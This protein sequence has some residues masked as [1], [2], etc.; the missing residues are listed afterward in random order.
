MRAALERARVLSELERHDEVLSLLGPVAPGHPDD[1]DLL[2]ELARAHLHLG[3]RRHHRTGLDL[4]RRALALDPDDPYLLA[5]LGQALTVS[6]TR[7]EEARSLL[8]AAVERA[9]QDPHLHLARAQAL[10]QMSLVRYDE[11]LAAADRAV[12]LAPRDVDALLLRATVL[13]QKYN[14]F[15]EAEKAE[16]LAA[17]RAVLAEDPANA[18]AAFLL[19]KIDTPLTGA[20]AAASYHE[21]VRRDPRHR[22]AIAKVDSVLVAPLRTGYWTLWLLTGIQAVLLARGVD[23]STWL[24]IAVFGLVVAVP[25]WRFRATRRKAPRGFGRDQGFDGWL[26]VFGVLVYLGV[27]TFR[28]SMHPVWGAGALWVTVV[29]LLL[30]GA[31]YL[32]R[33]HR[34]RRRFGG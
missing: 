31:A 5:L 9:P 21:A 28:A 25:W 19:A 20:Q 33:S 8:A 34:R 32:A 27:A 4:A 17:V 7:W 22:G 29:L 13:Q 2:A 24:T 1:P 18:E 11:A 26:L 6:P 10:E 23:G 16:A 15:H 14:P 3:G 30:A 12:E